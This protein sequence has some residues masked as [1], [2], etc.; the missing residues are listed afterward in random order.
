MDEHPPVRLHIVTGKGGTGKTT[1]ACALAFALASAGKRVLV[2]EVEGRQGLSEPLDVPHLDYTEATVPHPG[3]GTVLATAIDPEPALGEYLAKFYKASPVGA[4]LRRSGAVDFVTTIAPGLRDVLLTG[5]V[6]EAARRRE[7]G[8]NRAHVFDAVVMD[9]PPTGRIGRFL[10]VTAEVSSLAKV[11]PIHSQATSIAALLRSPE[12]AVHIVTLL[13]DMPVQE[14][15][16]A[17]QELSELGVAVGS[18]I[19]NQVE[20]AL[21]DRPLADLLAA[22]EDASRQVQEGLVAAGLVRP[23]RRTGP[24][25]RR[26]ARALIDDAAASLRRAEAQQQARALLAQ[27]GTPIVDILWRPVRSAHALATDVA[28]GLAGSELI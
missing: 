20:P 22:G 5:K 25:A 23:D 2:C 18:I 3:P 28:A 7:R 13:E 14:T 1:V 12:T 19:A 10:N 16:E 9:A 27:S 11:G 21:L 17:V 26:T 24:P 8:R 4:V 15:V 6:Y